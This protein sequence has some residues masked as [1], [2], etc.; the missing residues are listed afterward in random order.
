MNGFKDVNISQ[1]TEFID[2][3]NRFNVYF[4]IDEG[5]EF[6]FRDI[7]IDLQNINLSEDDNINIQ[8]LKDELTQKKLSKNKIYNPDF[9]N[10][11]KDKITEY[12]YD[13]GIV[14]F[15]IVEP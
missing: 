6:Q 15:D 7:N 2:S 9:I 1:Q 5:F 14:F 10:I 8:H 3:K 13:K 11:L 4:Y 12:L